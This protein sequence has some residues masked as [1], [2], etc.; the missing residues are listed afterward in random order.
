MKGEN[1]VMKKVLFVASEIAPFAKTGGLADV[2]GALPKS[3]SKIGMSVQL[4]MPLY[5]GIAE[6]F[7]LTLDGEISFMFQQRMRNVKIFKGVLPKT[8]INTYFLDEPGL[9]LRNG[10]Y[11]ENGKDYPDNADRFAHLSLAALE[12]CKAKQ[13]YPDIIHCHDWQTALVPVYLKNCYKNDNNLN[14]IATLLTIHNIA[15]QGLFPPKT[16]HEIGLSDSLFNI[17]GLEFWG[18]ISL[19]K[20]GLQ[21]SDCIN[22]VSKRY[23]EEIA[24]SAEFGRGLE[25]VLASRSTDLTGIVNGLDYDEWNPATDQFIPIQF[26]EKQIDK[27]QEMKQ[28]LLEDAGLKETPGFPLIGMISRL[29]DQKGWDLLANAMPELLKLGTQF[30]I[31]GTGD[32]KYHTLL[33]KLKK[34][35][36]SQIAVFLKFDNTLAHRIYAGSD[37]FLMPSRFEPCGL[38]Q[39]I[40]L[41]YGT[42]P[43]V[44]S[45]GGLADTISDVDTDK[46]G[47]GFSFEEYTETAMINTVK[48][49]VELYKKKRSWKTLVERAMK[50]DWSWESSAKEYLKLYEKAIQKKVPVLSGASC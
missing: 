43:L 48:R 29:D 5:K 46:K 27:K 34:E 10:L 6:Q 39:L 23:A 20:G 28:I 38:G 17:D 8:N 44:R 22:T 19:L 11:Q 16:L 21:F 33:E 50:E 36:P 30:I 32:P 3:L 25:G 26:D 31:L 42:I 40:S 13:Y 45:T 47:N 7:A 37:I 24:S 12:W 1:S 15:Y 49:A 4:F 18:Q 2:A 9:Y 41:K 14:K 35:F